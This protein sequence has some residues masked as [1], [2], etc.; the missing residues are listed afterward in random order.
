MIDIKNMSDEEIQ[1]ISKALN[2]ELVRRQR[3]LRA[4]AANK[5]LDALEEL[6]KIAPYCYVDMMDDSDA[7]EDSV[8][9]KPLVSQW[10]TQNF[11]FN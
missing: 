6:I 1:E 5:A 7:N 4:N 2:G 8:Y 11:H 3:A 10:K 9:L